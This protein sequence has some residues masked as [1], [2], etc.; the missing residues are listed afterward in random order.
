MIFQNVNQKRVI[1]CRRL[2]K[3]YEAKY[4]KRDRNNINTYYV[5]YT[6]NKQ[7]NWEHDLKITDFYIKFRKNIKNWLI[8]P[9]ICNIK[10]DVL[11]EIEI[12]S[13]RYL[14]AYELQLNGY[15][16]IEKYEKLYK[17][18]NWVGILPV[19]PIVVIN[20]KFKP[21]KIIKVISEEELYNEVA[22][23][24]KSFRS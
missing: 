2:K 6:G 23:G 4:L 16:D 5:Y 1:A 7:K 3:L 13:N 24:S 12:K 8:E 20:G 11:A 22:E 21:S 10:P 9:Q 15:A 19:F 18:N 17:S 14:I